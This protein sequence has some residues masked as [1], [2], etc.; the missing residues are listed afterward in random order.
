MP[1]GVCGRPPAVGLLLIRRLV[2]GFGT[3]ATVKT[4]HSAKHSRS[5]KKIRKPTLWEYLLCSFPLQCTSPDDGMGQYLWDPRSL[6]I[7]AKPRGNIPGSDCESV[8]R[9]GAEVSSTRRR[10][11]WVNLRRSLRVRAW[12]V[13]SPSLSL[14]LSIECSLWLLVASLVGTW[15]CR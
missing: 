13:P 10:S 15:L 11:P 2:A 14:S 1:K 6:M 8:C 9:G 3:P 4:L 12:N 7:G 5:I